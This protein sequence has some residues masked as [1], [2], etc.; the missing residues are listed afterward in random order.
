MPTASFDRKLLFVLIALEALIFYNFYSREI[1]GFP[2]QNFDQST[3]LLQAYKLEQRVFSK[4]LGVFSSAL[5]GKENPSGLL[6]PI[7][8]AFSGLLIGGS[9]LPQLLVL[10]IAFSAL[11]VFAFTTAQAVWSRRAY[12]YLVLGLILCQTTAWYFAGG[13]FDFR[14]DFVAYCLYGI[15]TCAVVRS[16]LFLDRRWTIV[17]G[18]IGA[19]LVLHRFITIIY[20]LG[21]CAGFA[22]ASLIVCRFLRGDPALPDRFKRRLSNLA[23]AAVILIFVTGPVLLANWGAIHD[24]YVLG[25]ATGQEKY[26]RASEF[27]VH[28]LAGFFLFYP[29]SIVEGH[30]GRTF[31]RASLLAIAIGV[32]ARLLGRA[33]D[34]EDP[35]SSSRAE[36]YLL[37][38]IFLLGAILGPVTV[39]TIDISKSPIVGGIVAV[40]VA[41]LVI[42]LW[43]PDH[44]AQESAYSRKLI[45]ACGIVIFV[46][47]LSTQFEHACRHLPEYARRRDLEK[48]AELDRWLVQ[49]AS[50]HDWHNPQ[51]S[52]DVISGWFNSNA[53]TVSGFEQTGELIEFGTLLGGGI[54]GVERPEALSMLANSDFAILTTIQKEG[55]YPFYERVSRY[56]NDLKSWADLHMIVARTVPF[57]GFRAT[58]YVR[59]SAK[60]SGLSGGWVTPDG[61]TIEATPETLRRFPVIRLTGDASYSPLSRVPTVTAAIDTGPATEP[62]PAFLHENANSYEILLDLSKIEPPQS[63]PV[64]VRLAFD[65]FFIPKKMGISSDTREL[66]LPA[67]SQVRLSPPSP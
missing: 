21:V 14:M 50:D 39:L 48:V 47:G 52:F 61:F 33:R 34:S 13:L 17:S 29:K 28:D 6:L 15:W 19:F 9:R 18:L 67:P 10:F 24:Y 25:H 63:D 27:G 30:L 37:R 56:W 1:A 55:V 4:S 58:V 32:V 59:P 35:A 3:Y 36:T 31:L 23:L 66:V 43:A 54:M 12:G 65:T 8:G 53:I 51:I 62:V 11:Q 5:W 20:L 49:Y 16:D 60:L 64:Q 2:P 40:P 45:A 46:F 26:V 22:I 57:D 7:E 42:A 38:N 41:L 44:R